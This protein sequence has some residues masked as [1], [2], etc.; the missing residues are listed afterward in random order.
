MLLD[1]PIEGRY[2]VTDLF[3]AGSHGGEPRPVDTITPLA[4]AVAHAFDLAVRPVRVFL[5]PR[6]A[7]HLGVAPSAEA[8]MGEVVRIAMRKTVLDQ[9][10]M[11][12]DLPV[13]N[14]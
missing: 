7:A 11:L 8:R 9:M 4:K 14:G 1:V 3:V 12:D 10:Q 6:V 2:Q 13:G 5:R